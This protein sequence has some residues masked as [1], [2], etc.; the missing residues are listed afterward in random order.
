M[1]HEAKDNDCSLLD[2][3]RREN[4]TASWEEKEFGETTDFQIYI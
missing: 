4:N 1:L 2:W 3:S